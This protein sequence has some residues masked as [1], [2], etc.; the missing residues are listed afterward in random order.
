MEFT[1]EKAARTTMVRSLCMQ[2]LSW[3]RRAPS[4]ADLNVGLADDVRMATYCYHVFD[5]GEVAA[6]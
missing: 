2:R 1:R 3:A 6:L 4:P 5:G